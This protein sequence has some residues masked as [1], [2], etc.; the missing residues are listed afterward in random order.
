MS[1]DD[2]IAVTGPKSG[3][4][5]YLGPVPAA[6]VAAAD[7]TKLSVRTSPV[8]M[9]LNDRGGV[10]NRTA[11]CVADVIAVASVTT[12]A[13]AQQANRLD[14]TNRATRL[15]TAATLIECSE[16]AFGGRYRYIHVYA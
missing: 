4:K 7:V 3:A 10:A 2:S 15:V 13:V 14:D 1:A 6:C 8:A 9:R 12:S 5:S 11:G 16:V